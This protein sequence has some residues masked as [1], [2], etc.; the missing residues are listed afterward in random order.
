MRDTNQVHIFVYLDWISGVHTFPSLTLLWWR[1]STAKA[2][3]ETSS[4]P[5]CSKALGRNKVACS[6]K[7]YNL[8]RSHTKTCPVCG[9]VFYDS[10]SNDTVACGPECSKRH[11]Q[12]LHAWGVY[13]SMQAAHKAIP[14]HPLTGPDV[15]WG[16]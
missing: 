4:C 3:R 11:R 5:I 12:Q 16:T 6:R 10:P 13:D 7:C 9:K 14:S 1:V 2:M 8:W 15:T